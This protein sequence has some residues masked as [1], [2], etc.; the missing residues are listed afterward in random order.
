MAK[1]KF[2]LTAFKKQADRNDHFGQGQ[3]GRGSVSRQADRVVGRCHG[4]GTQRGR[5]FAI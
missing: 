2:S 1:V 4:R 5:S 3:H